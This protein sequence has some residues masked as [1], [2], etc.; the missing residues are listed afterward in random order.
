MDNCE[1]WTLSEL[2]KAIDT[3]QDKKDKRIVVPMFQRGE[4]WNT[5]QEMKFID[6]LK[7]GFPVGTML[8][9]FFF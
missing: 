9:F 4:R 6:S 5:K 2:A 1:N 8:F 3:N 7:R